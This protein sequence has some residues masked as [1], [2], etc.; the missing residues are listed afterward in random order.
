MQTFWPSVSSQEKF[1]SIAQ[2]KEIISIFK[3][4]EGNKK[5]LIADMLKSASRITLPSLLCDGGGRKEIPRVVSLCRCPGQ[6]S[7][8]LRRHVR[9]T[10]YGDMQYLMSS[11]QVL[12]LLD[13]GVTAPHC[14]SLTSIVVLPE[15]NPDFWTNKLYTAVDV[16]Q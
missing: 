5:Y 4:I 16:R 13:W 12:C 6:Q 7:F 8:S 14:H 2:I 15:C 11:L 9:D 1:L 10:M 3:K